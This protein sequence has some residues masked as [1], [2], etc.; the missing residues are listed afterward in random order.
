VYWLVHRQDSSSSAPART[1]ARSRHAFARTASAT[2]CAS[3][4]AA[5][6]GDAPR[7]R[8]S[9]PTSSPTSGVGSGSQSRRHQS[10]SRRKASRPSTSS[11]PS[12]STA[13]RG[14]SGQTRC[15]P[16]STR[17]PI[18][19][20]RFFGVPAVRDHGRGGRPL[21]AF[22]GPRARRIAR[23]P[24]ARRARPPAPARERDDQ[25]DAD[26]ARPDPG[27]GGGVRLSRAQSRE[28]SAKASPSGFA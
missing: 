24:R 14:S 18:T 25:Q 1:A 15:R 28:G 5:M 20:C 6:A 3:V 22:Q 11:H 21:P 27:G 12:G 2:T 7:R 23:G 26:A 17:S 10:P 19:C 8:P 13:R 4:T 16:T 9:W